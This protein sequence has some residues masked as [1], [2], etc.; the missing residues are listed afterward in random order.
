MLRTNWHAFVSKQKKSLSVC[1]WPKRHTRLALKL[2]A[3]GERHS[4]R[5]HPGAIHVMST[6]KE[7][8]FRLT[9]SAEDRKVDY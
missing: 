6:L 8:W 3:S 9:V 4:C 1:R 5:R 7:P 2:I